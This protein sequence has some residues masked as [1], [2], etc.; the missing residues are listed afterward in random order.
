MKIYEI[1]K[2]GINLEF[3]NL[4]YK[5]KN[6]KI[7]LYSTKNIYPSFKFINLSKNITFKKLRIL[8]GEGNDQ[9][10]NNNNNNG[11]ENNGN[12]NNNENNG[13]ENNN[14]NDNNNNE[15][16]GN[17]NGNENNDNNN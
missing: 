2:N 6:Y 15:Y 16:N 5:Q 10:I 11:N 9:N 1:N 17:N 3:Y 8:N 7:L 14:N 4:I 13:N 12:N